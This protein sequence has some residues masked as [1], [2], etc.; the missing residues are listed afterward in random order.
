MGDD[1]VSQPSQD[2]QQSQGQQPA[3]VIPQRTQTEERLATSHAAEQ[4]EALGLSINPTHVEDDGTVN[5]PLSPI[6]SSTPNQ[7]N[8]VNSMDLE[9]YFKGPRDMS[10][11]SKWPMFMQMHGSILPSMIVPLLWIG[12]W[13]SAITVI[14]KH[15]YSLGVNSVLLTVTGFVVSLGLSLRS[16]TA[17]ERYTEGRKYWA[18]LILSSQQL[19]RLFWVHAR[20]NDPD[21]KKKHL[22]QTMTAT[23][24][25]VAFSI[26]LKHKLRFEPYTAYPDL[27]HLVSHLDTF[28]GRA[29]EEIAMHHLIQKK[30]FFKGVGEH[31]GL[32]FA[33]SNPRKA[34]K[35]ACKPLGN[36]PLEILNFLSHYV[37]NLVADG[38][39]PVPMQQTIAYNNLAMLNDILTGTER[40]LTTPLPIAYGIAISQITWVYVMVLPFQLYNF[41]G[42]V[43]IPASII[44]SYIILGILFIGREIENP[45]GMDVNDLPLD[46]FCDQVADELDVIAAQSMDM[47]MLMSRI[48]TD[49]NKV[50]YPASST[51]FVAWMYRDEEKLKQAIRRKPQQTFEQRH[52]PE[53]RGGSKASSVSTGSD[54]NV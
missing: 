42:W 34:L 45:F 30:S 1:G 10:K 41:L 21:K 25:V 27:M 38:K 53:S 8:R 52:P 44:A 43:T 50:F 35:R 47:E 12:V 9:N 13:S 31:L 2:Q 51:S 29:T 40:V 5:V 4:A 36:L 20:E 14:S 37:D 48:E 15:V 17:Y 18:Q 22:L 28:A 24:M 23:N 33:E 16:S 19:G 54:L 49:R 39:L 32:S 11:H 3:L 46:I 7:I 6:F 26:A